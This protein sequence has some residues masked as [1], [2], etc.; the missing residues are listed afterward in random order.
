M[1]AF[2][3]RFMCAFYTR[4]EVLKIEIVSAYTL[5]NLYY[6]DSIEKP[7]YGRF[8]VSWVQRGI[9]MKYMYYVY[10]I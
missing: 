6:I 1:M 9:A 2:F 5:R 10:L 3:Y 4:E 7:E 8:F